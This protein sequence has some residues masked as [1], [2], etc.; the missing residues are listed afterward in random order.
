MERSKR[1]ARINKNIN[2]EVRSALSNAME[3]GEIVEELQV[4]GLVADDRVVLEKLSFLGERWGLNASTLVE[5]YVAFQRNTDLPDRISQKNVE[6]FDRETS[7]KL[8]TSKS[9]TPKSHV[10]KSAKSLLTKNMLQELMVAEAC[11]DQRDLLSSYG[12]SK[13]LIPVSTARLIPSNKEN[14]PEIESRET[15]LIASYPSEVVASLIC[16]GITDFIDWTP[17]LLTTGT[18]GNRYMNQHTLENA[19]TPSLISGRVSAKLSVPIKGSSESSQITENNKPITE[20]KTRLHASN[21][22]LVGLRRVERSGSETDAVPLDLGFSKDLSCYSIYSGQPLLIRGVNP[23]GHSLGA[24][25][26]FQIPISKPPFINPDKCS[27]NLHIMVACGPYT[28]SNSHDPTGLFNLLRCVK[29]CKPHVLILLGPF[30][31]SEHPG[32]QSYSETTYEELFQSRVNSVS[33]WCSHLSIRLIIISSWRE[34]HHDPVYP[35]PPIDKSWIE[36]TPHL[37]IHFAPDPCLFQIGEYVFGLTSVDILKDLSCEEIS[38]GCSG[39]DRITRLCRHILASSSF[40]PVH[41]PDDGL[42][43]DYPLWSQ[44]AQFSVTPHCLI[45]PSKLRQFVK[46][47]D[48]VL[49]INP[50]YV[51]R[52]EAFGSY[53]EIVVNGNEF[54]SLSENSNDINSYIPDNLSPEHSSSSIC[55][56]TS[57]LIKRL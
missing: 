5:K 38:A 46:N 2:Q 20:T 40:Y 6:L 41:P 16:N 48:G 3:V 22:A 34:L 18:H 31:D 29:Q 57:V 14:E 9:R 28:L 8:D 49:C 42:P 54:S 52:G 44:Y 13:E 4:F 45:L 19:E 24:M 1:V 47:V 23:T 55:G 37:V 36:K 25:E 50:G 17:T 32:I 11:S 7:A 27:G 39:S 12:V 53:A 26:I 56:R 51:S 30:V 33:E 35:T 10:T 21:V 15:Q 43:L